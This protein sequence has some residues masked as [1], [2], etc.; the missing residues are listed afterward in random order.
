MRLRDRVRERLLDRVARQQQ[1]TE[2][3]IVEEVE[4][5]GGVP[6]APCAARPR[7]T[8]RDRS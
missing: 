2:Q 8:G 5:L 3:R 6:Q 7:A 4:R 1:R